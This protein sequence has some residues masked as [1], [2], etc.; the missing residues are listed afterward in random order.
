MYEWMKP[1]PR[2]YGVPCKCANV[3]STHMSPHFATVERFQQRKHQRSRKWSPNSSRPN[4]EGGG[5]YEK[6]LKELIHVKHRCIDRYLTLVC[7]WILLEWIQ[8]TCMLQCLSL[9]ILTWPSDKH[10]GG[11]VWGK[12]HMCR[13]KIQACF[14]QS[15]GEI[16]LLAFLHLHPS[17]GFQK[18]RPRPVTC[19]ESP[20][21]ATKEKSWNLMLRMRYVAM[22]VYIVMTMP[23]I[24]VCDYPIPPSLIP[25]SMHTYAHKEGAKFTSSYAPVWQGVQA[26]AAPQAI[27]TQP[28]NCEELYHDKP[29]RETLVQQILQKEK[30]LHPLPRIY[31]V[32]VWAELRETKVVFPYIHLLSESIRRSLS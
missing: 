4:T 17:R 26:P 14:I 29:T 11:K 19:P 32:T 22:H 10:W 8:C 24:I 18:M 12:C 20:A 5:M 1:W 16:K 30:L 31:I 23:T 27:D 3:P 25:S 28:F 2:F 7:T 6:W 9:A 15:Y 21:M 13:Y